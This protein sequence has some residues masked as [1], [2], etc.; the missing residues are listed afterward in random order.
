MM[1]TMATNAETLP[2]LP[3]R[4]LLFVTYDLVTYSYL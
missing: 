1:S 2:S 4:L 3:T